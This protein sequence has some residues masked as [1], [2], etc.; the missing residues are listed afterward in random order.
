MLYDLFE[1][2]PGAPNGVSTLDPKSL[3][4][5]DSVVIDGARGP[6]VDA[7]VKYI[8]PKWITVSING[9]TNSTKRCSLESGNPFVY[10]SRG[11]VTGQLFK[12]HATYNATFNALVDYHT[13]YR[14]HRSCIINALK[15]NTLTLFQLE[16]LNTAFVRVVVGYSSNTKSPALE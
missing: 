11:V 2:F 3:S 6:A 7:T 13:A 12:D 1:N 16:A 8:G 9:R 15:E 4:V 10:D 14:E 5:G